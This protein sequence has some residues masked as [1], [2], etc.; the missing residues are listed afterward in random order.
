MRQE[1]AADAAVIG[2]ATLQRYERGEIPSALHH[3]ARLAYLLGYGRR[4]DLLLDDAVFEAAQR[5]V[6][7]LRA[8]DLA[9]VIGD[10]EART[11]V[12]QRADS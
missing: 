2:R 3:Y 8:G 11:V 7:E 9:D 12:R 6:E 4:I 1:D 10:I 5:E